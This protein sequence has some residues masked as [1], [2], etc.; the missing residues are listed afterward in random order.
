MTK[1]S[2]VRLIQIGDIHYPP[3]DMDKPDVD[4]KDKTL[5][6]ELVSKVGGNKITKVISR[7]H[8][9][10][11]ERASVLIFM[12]DLSNKGKLAD[13][14]ACANYIKRTIIS[15]IEVAGNLVSSHLVPGN[16]DVDR[17][18]PGGQKFKKLEEICRAVGLPPLPTDSL[19]KQ[20]I[21]SSSPELARLYLCN[22]CVGCGETR[23]LPDAISK[24]LAAASI[25]G[26]DILELTESLD[27]PTIEQDVLDCVVDDIKSLS[28]FCIPVVVAHHNILPQV[29]PRLMVYGE[30]LNAGRV[31]DGLISS[32]RAIIY[33]HGHLHHDPIEI[34][35]D[36]MRDQ[37]MILTVSAPELYKGFNIV[38]IHYDA[39][40]QP[41]KAAIT[42]IRIDHT[43]SETNELASILLIDR[44]TI[45]QQL[46]ADDQ[47]VL[48]Q[49]PYEGT[50]IKP[51]MKKV[52]RFSEAQLCTIVK[53]LNDL[54]L[55]RLD[56]RD[57]V[58]DSWRIFKI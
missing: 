28:K 1:T 19:I 13:Y 4:D 7:I 47:F 6:V 53:A 20:S 11:A 17:D 43:G 32:K 41:L 31:R 2:I 27:A 48:G 9:A 34:I 58:P 54:G 38:D 21:P 40:G 23:R 12:G 45:V 35:R 14:E 22:S 24:K 49:I 29:Q 39:H 16:H 52:K 26:I 57:L 33:L 36:P 56:N 15:P 25:P 3:K 18:L 46:T 5:P 8:K 44:P 42:K 30:M 37:S 55:I 10:A 51:L 50:F